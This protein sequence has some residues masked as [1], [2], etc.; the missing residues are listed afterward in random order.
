[1]GSIL[2]AGI[3]L[4]L[5]FYAFMRL[6][7]LC[8]NGWYLI[9]VYTILFIGFLV[10]CFSAFVKLDIKKIIALSTLS[11]LGVMMFTIGAGEPLLC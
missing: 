6:L 10:P 3:L 8:S 7:F 11:Q 1:M 2:L 9:L 4:K 5:S